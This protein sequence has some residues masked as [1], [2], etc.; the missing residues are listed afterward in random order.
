MLFDAKL[1][2]NEIVNKN[3]IMQLC[4]NAMSKNG[5]HPFFLFQLNLNV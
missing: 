5:P 3:A 1:Y 2:F 4:K